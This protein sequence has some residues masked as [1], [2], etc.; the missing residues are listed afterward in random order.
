MLVRIFGRILAAFLALGTLMAAIVIA[1]LVLLDADDYRR[2]TIYLAERFTGRDVEIS[3]PF[4]LDISTQPT[5]SVSGL[6]VANPSWADEPDLAQVG[7]LEVQLALWPL[8]SGKISVPRLALSD[9]RFAPEVGADGQQSWAFGTR[10]EQ[11]AHSEIR[12]PLLSDVKL[13]KVD[14]HF[15]NAATGKAMSVELA[16]LAV[17]ETNGVNR[18]AGAGAWG[19]RVFSVSGHLGTLGEALKPTGDFPVDVS[20]SM[21]GVTA[22]LSGQVADPVKGAGLDLHLAVFADDLKEL[23]LKVGKHPELEGWLDARAVISGSVTALQLSGIHL[24]LS[25]DTG[26]T[27]SPA[28]LLLTG[29]IERVSPRIGDLA[30]GLN[31]E[32]SVTGSTRNLARIFSAQIPDLGNLDSSFTLQGNSASLR[33]PEARIRI[34]NPRHLSVA[35][36]GSLASIDLAGEFSFS[37]ADFQMR[38]TAPTTAA[39]VMPFGLSLPELGKV[40]IN[41]QLGGDFQQLDLQQISVEVGS[42]NQAMDL[43]GNVENIMLQGGKPANVNFAGPIA[44]WLDALLER[45]L[46]DL[47]LVHVSAELANGDSGVRLDTLRVLADDTTALS[48]SASSVAGKGA[49]AFDVSVAARDLAALGLNLPPLGP[50]SYDGYITRAPGSLHVSGTSQLGQSIMRESMNVGLAGP[51]PNVSGTLVLPIVY[52]RDLGFYPDGPWQPE[53]QGEPAQLPVKA[54]KSVNLSLTVAV[55]H[56]EGRDLTIE[57]ASAAIDLEDGNLRLRPLRFDLVGGSFELYAGVNA[58][59]SPP[60]VSTQVAG[61]NVNLEQVFSQIR[62]DVPLDGT[63]DL[64]WDLNTSGDTVADMIASLDGSLD[65][66]VSNGSIHNPYFDLLGT[67]LIHWLLA[68][69]H[70]RSATDIHCFIGQFA[71]EKGDAR[72]RSLLLETAETLSLATGDIDLVDERLDIAVQPHTLGS[73]LQLSTPYRVV[74]PWSN[75]QVDYN[76]WRLA[77]RAVEE[78]ALAPLFTLEDFAEILRGQNQDRDNPCLDWAPTPTELAAVA[79]RPFDF[80]RE[81]YGLIAFP[82][83]S[84]VALT[85]IRVR[86]GPGPEFDRIRTLQAGELLN[87][88]GKLDRMN[89]YHVALAGG[90]SGYVW[91]KLIRPVD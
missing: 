65:I 52:L 9:A 4:S 60:A 26:Q 83:T 69:G 55:D 56:I 67:D 24:T 19:D 51:K 30:S 86:R 1:A 13:N 3:G 32:A 71:L 45:K 12:V 61:E 44:P 59:V 10:H 17:D 66:A 63:L 16:D 15:R 50:F 88:T 89:W 68:G 36:T 76:H 38:A 5:F 27:A 57:N 91:G 74:G 77:V 87:V 28:R 84:F 72:S 49:S 34:G 18:V 14:V 43:A 48:F 40:S 79:H 73:L 78:L 80:N 7:Q 11:R 25:E 46:P 53:A 58:R 47:G 54:L 41:G 33:I 90:D 39:A 2:F 35:A 6:S 29:S 23:H 20:M 62:K 31:L 21:S 22:K 82:R 85:D 70:A 42:T 37:G 64:R 75:P 8:L 81:G